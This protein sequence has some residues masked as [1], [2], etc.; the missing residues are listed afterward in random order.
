M[1]RLA[2]TETQP[3]V[4]TRVY[5]VL[6]IRRS[7]ARSRAR[8][9]GKGAD[10]L[11]RHELLRTARGAVL[12]AGDGWLDAGASAPSGRIPQRPQVRNILDADPQARGDVRGQRYPRG[13]TPSD[14]VPNDIFERATTLVLT[15]RNKGPLYARY[16]QLFSAQIAQPP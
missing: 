3:L 11:R 1:R 10:E 5:P 7:L 4:I 14:R 6:W 8:S 15:P 16:E 9:A 2:G 12:V 13:S